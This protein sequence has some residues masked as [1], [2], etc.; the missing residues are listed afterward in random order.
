MTRIARM[1]LRAIL[2]RLICLFR[3]AMCFV[4]F[5]TNLSFHRRNWFLWR[6]DEFSMLLWIAGEAWK[7]SGSGLGLSSQR[8]LWRR[9]KRCFAA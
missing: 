9:M 4:A 2:C 6:T 7:C 1:E 8:R 3:M 5:I